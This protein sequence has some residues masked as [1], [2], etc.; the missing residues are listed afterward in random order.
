MG[1]GDYAAVGALREEC[2]H[3][4]YFTSVSAV[5]ETEEL[6]TSDLTGSR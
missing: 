2:I 4:D 1:S 6:V 5:S 3:A